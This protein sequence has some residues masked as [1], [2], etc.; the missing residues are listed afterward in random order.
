MAYKASDF[1][2]NFRNIQ[3]TS[4]YLEINEPEPPE[5]NL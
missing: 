5:K 1:L 2:K 3:Q 4:A